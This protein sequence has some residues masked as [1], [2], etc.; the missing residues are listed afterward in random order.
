MLVTFKYVI[1]CRLRRR[2]NLLLAAPSMSTYKVQ[3]STVLR[4]GFP[5][6]LLLK[7]Y[8]WGH[9]TQMKISKLDKKFK[10]NQNLFL[11]TTFCKNIFHFGVRNIYWQ[12]KS[13]FILFFWFLVLFWKAN[14]WVI[15]RLRQT[16]VKAQN[17]LW[18]LVKSKKQST[19]R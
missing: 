10:K 18:V 19:Q 8:V 3:S 17:A 2:V 6:I 7:H 12:N 13:F 9:I 1:K 15:H 16:V 4:D 5:Q 14:E 11:N